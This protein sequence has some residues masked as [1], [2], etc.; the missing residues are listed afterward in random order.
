MTGWDVTAEELRTRARRIVTA[1][2]LYNLPRRLERRRRY[3]AEA[4]PPRR[5][6]PGGSAEAT[7]PRERLSAMIAAYYAARGWDAV[8]RVPAALVE[9]L[10]L[11]DLRVDS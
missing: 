4:L 7:L 2:K 5:S 3:P 10:S 9:T 11:Y 6:P 1:K 8:G